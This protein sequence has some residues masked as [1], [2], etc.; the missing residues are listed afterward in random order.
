MPTAGGGLCAFCDAYTPPE[1][2]PQQLDV[3]V[4]RIDLLRADLNKILDSLP[5]DAPL[6]GCAD[7]T[8]GICHL[9][10]ASVAID[11]AADTLEAVEV[12]R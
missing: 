6:F 8:T 7:L 10:R 11:R 4:N 9:K 2:V 5:S 12:V 1:T 3:A